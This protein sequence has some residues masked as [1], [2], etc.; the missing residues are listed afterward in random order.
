MNNNNHD[1]MPDFWLEIEMAEVWVFWSEIYWKITND[2]CGNN[3]KAYELQLCCF[4]KK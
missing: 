1:L 2:N 3:Q 4:N